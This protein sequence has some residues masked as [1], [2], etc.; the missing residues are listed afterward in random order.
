MCLIV[1]GGGVKAETLYL[2]KSGTSVGFITG[3]H[4]Q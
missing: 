1:G 4:G 3:E 2:K